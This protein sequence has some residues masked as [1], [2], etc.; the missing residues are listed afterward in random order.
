[1]QNLSIRNFSGFILVILISLL[2]CTNY[3][4][5]KNDEIKSA[6][7]ANSSPTFHG[8]YYKGSDARYH[9][10]ESKWDFKKNKF[11]KMPVNKLAIESGYTFKRGN[12]ELRVDLFNDNGSLFAQNEFCKLYVKQ[13]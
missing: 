2:S 5:L 4:E 13:P 3:Q 8:Y 9:Y 12:K 10:F 6:F 7:I 1:M 11:F